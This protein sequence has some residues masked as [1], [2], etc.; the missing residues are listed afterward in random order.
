MYGG[1]WL[2]DVLRYEIVSTRSGLNLYSVDPDTAGVRLIGS[3]L[4]TNFSFDV[5]C[6]YSFV[7]FMYVVCA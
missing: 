5:V 7:V 2:Q 4:K 6:Y 1:V 3:L